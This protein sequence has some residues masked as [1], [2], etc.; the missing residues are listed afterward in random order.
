MLTCATNRCVHDVKCWRDC[1]K[2]K[3]KDDKAEIMLCGKNCG[4]RHLTVIYIDINGHSLKSAS[5][6]MN[7]SVKF[8][9]DV[10]MQYQNK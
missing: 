3:L 7:F 4:N 2:L 9:R 10:P 8:G 6:I 5:K 1:I